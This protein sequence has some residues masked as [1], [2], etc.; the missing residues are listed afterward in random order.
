MYRHL[1]LLIPLLFLSS[2]PFTLSVPQDTPP[3]NLPPP[4]PVF[5]IENLLVRS[6]MDAG[7]ASYYF[8]VYPLH[9]G[10]TSDRYRASVTESVECQSIGWD[11]S[12]VGEQRLA[13]PKDGSLDARI[14]QPGS[15]KPAVEGFKLLITWL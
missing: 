11:T 9:P 1:F 8:R 5:H 7:I 14:Q 15:R 10:Y 12:V 13:C 6:P 2:V 3:P 4:N